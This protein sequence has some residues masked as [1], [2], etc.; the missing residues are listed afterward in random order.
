MPIF[1]YRCPRCGEDFE[2]LVFGS[3]PVE[4]PKCGCAKPDKKMS[5]F[6][7]AGTREKGGDRSRS[8]GLAS[9]GSSCSGCS[10]SSCA[11]CH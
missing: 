10:S 2:K 6:G 8:T 5:M 9:S 3:T 7:M 11:G 4:C 1:E